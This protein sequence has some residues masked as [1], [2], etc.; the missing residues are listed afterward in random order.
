MSIISYGRK[1][2]QQIYVKRLIDVQ[3]RDGRE[4]QEQ[5][6]ELFADEG[7]RLEARPRA[8]FA[9]KPIGHRQPEVMHVSSIT[10]QHW[11]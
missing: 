2:C 3:E 11:Y 5:G 1:T 8:A 4:H 6:Y 10:S 9:F 7:V